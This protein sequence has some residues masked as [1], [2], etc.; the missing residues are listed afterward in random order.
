MQTIIRLTIIGFISTIVYA[1]NVFG[2]TTVY[3][4]YDGSG[5]RYLRTITLTSSL[6]SVKVDTSIVSKAVNDD[7]KKDVFKDKL[8]DKKIL[9]Y[10]NPTQGQLKIDIEGY[11]EE[12][13]SGMYLYNLSGG[14]LINKSPANSSQVFDLSNYAAGAYI[15]KI[16]IGEKVSEWKIMKE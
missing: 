6:K 5:S 3:Y 7:T 9:I 2:Q 16:V 13:N 11:Q 12:K 1:G 14:L 15:L 4:K 8:D 10:P